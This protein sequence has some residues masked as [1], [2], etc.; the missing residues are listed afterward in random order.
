MTGNLLHEGKVKLVYQDP[1]SEDRVIIEFTDF[2]TAGDGEKRDEFKGKGELACR[3]T[4]YLLGFLEGKGID[5]HFIKALVGPKL[6]CRKVEIY[7]IEVVCRNIAA[8]SFCKRYGVHKGKVLDEPLVE[9]FLKDDKLHDPLI[10]QDAIRSMGLVTDENL[11]FM[12]SVTLSVNYYLSELLKQNNLTLVDFKLE[13]GFTQAGHIVLADELSGDSIRVWDPKSKS[14]DKDA[15][16]DDKGDLV[17]AYS[18]LLDSITKT[19]SEDI[20]VR[21]ETVQVFVKPKNGIKN[22]PGEVTKKALL[23]LGFG[24]AEDVRVGKVFN[25]EL[26][27]PLSTEILNHLKIMN[28]KLLS[29]PISEKHEVKLS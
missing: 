13:F 19:R 12:R 9:F 21:K 17:E 29:N 28:I 1:D 16:R 8:G 2:V 18:K 27:R 11:Q 25:I 7:P 10:S 22:P 3:M 5:T 4:E 24:E 20:P 23:R 26:R 6:L 15:F 14:L